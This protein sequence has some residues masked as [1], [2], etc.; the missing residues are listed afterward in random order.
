MGKPGEWYQDDHIGGYFDEKGKLV[1]CEEYGS[2]ED[3]D[4]YSV[5]V[6]NGS[7][8]YDSSGRFKRYYDED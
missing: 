3:F 6:Q 5:D 4:K 7:G 2:D 1:V 8:Y